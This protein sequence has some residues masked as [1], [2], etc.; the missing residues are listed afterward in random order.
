M[1]VTLGGRLDQG[2]QALEAARWD[3]ARGAFES[4]LAEE[5]SPEALDGLGLALWFLGDVREAIVARE[6]AVE[7]YARGDRCDDAARL[8]VW[9]S[10]QHLIGGRTSA[11]RGWLA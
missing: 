11:A 4:A 7:G 6:Q 8:A 2:R 9:V 5:E 3:E 10:H 1:D